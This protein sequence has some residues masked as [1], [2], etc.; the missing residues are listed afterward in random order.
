[1]SSSHRGKPFHYLA[2]FRAWSCVEVRADSI[3]ENAYKKI[4][5][6]KLT[7]KQVDEGYSLG[8]ALYQKAYSEFFADDLYIFGIDRKGM[9][10][11]YDV[12]SERYPPLEEL[13]KPVYVNDGLEGIS[14][15]EVSPLPSPNSLVAST[16]TAGKGVMGH[17]YLN[18]NSPFDP[19]NLNFTLTSGEQFGIDEAAID[20]ISYNDSDE[21]IHEKIDGSIYSS[22]A[23][24]FE[25]FCCSKFDDNLKC[26]EL[27][28]GEDW[29]MSVL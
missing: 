1:M 24:K 14:V 15:S 9:I 25:Q 5:K 28:D 12:G 17:V 8:Y 20:S 4:R 29:V 26:T 10:E 11:V 3:S 19:K 16:V 23:V 18:L 21:S 22:Y 2:I 27:F 6:T 13:T 7:K